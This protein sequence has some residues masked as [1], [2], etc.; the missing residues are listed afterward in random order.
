MAVGSSAHAAGETRRRIALPK[1][2]VF[3]ARCLSNQFAIP[4]KRTALMAGDPRKPF[5]HRH[6]PGPSTGMPL[7]VHGRFVRP[8]WGCRTPGSLGSPQIF[9]K[10][11]IQPGDAILNAVPF[12]RA[13]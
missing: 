10:A 2:F 9:A 1:L 12:S 4:G 8:V 5:L 7:S 3:V 11:K 13:S 6:P